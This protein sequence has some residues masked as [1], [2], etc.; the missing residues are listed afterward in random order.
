MEDED[1]AADDD[2]DDGDEIEET[3]E[4]YEEATERTTSIATTTTTT[5]ESVEEVVRGKFTSIRLGAEKLILLLCIFALYNKKM[6]QTEKYPKLQY[7]CALAPVIC[8]FN[9]LTF[10]FPIT[11]TVWS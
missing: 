3:E 8:V 11:N 5:T 2:D 7:C 1:A 6:F 9:P 10:P 4:E